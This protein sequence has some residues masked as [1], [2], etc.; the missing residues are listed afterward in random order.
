[1]TSTV[2]ISNVDCEAIRPRIGLNLGSLL[3]FMIRNA[4]PLTKIS[5]YGE[6]ILIEGVLHR[7]SH[8]IPLRLSDIL[9][10]LSW[11]RVILRKSSVSNSDFNLNY[12]WHFYSHCPSLFCFSLIGYESQK[13]KQFSM[14]IGLYIKSCCLTGILLYFCNNNKFLL[15]YWKC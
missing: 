4:F 11:E 9:V 8:S 6:K 12:V 10:F 1:M 13:W 15:P 14:V 7:R 2:Y 3:S 5:I